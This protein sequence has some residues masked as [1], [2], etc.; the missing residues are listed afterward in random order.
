M[1]SAFVSPAVLRSAR[2]ITAFTLPQSRSLT[3]FRPRSR[4]ASSRFLFNM[5]AVAAQD[6]QQSTLAHGYQYD[7]FVIGAGSGGVRASRIAAN[8]GAKVAVAEYAPL[9]GTCVNVGCVPK[10]LFVYGSHYG[11]DFHDASAYGWDV[12]TP[13]LDWSR[14]IRNKNAEIER[15]NGIYGR[16]LDKAGVHLIQGKAKFVDSHTVQVGDAQ[17]TADKILV[18]TG[19]H[20]F[21]PQFEGR[22][23]AITSNEAFYLEQLPKRCL[24]V[25]G[26]YIA[27]EFACIFHGYGSQIVQLYR[28]DL[29]LRGFDD[30]VRKHLAE[31]MR[32]TG[33]DVRFNSNVKRIVKNADGSF[34]VTSTN[35]ELFETDLVLYATG[36]VP[37]TEGIALEA[38]G[39]KTGDSGKIL[40][41]DW[42]KTNVDHIYAI[43]DVTDRVCLTPVAI[44]EGHAFADTLYGDKKRN[45]NYN[46]IPTAVFS[47]PSIGT[48]GL[49]ETQ[50]REKYGKNG[51]DVYKTAFRPMKHTLTKREGEKTFMKLIVEKS[52]D[53][54]V[55]CHLLDAAA[56]EVIQILGVAMKAGATKADFDATMPVH[57][58]SAEEI[59]TLRTK[60]PDPQ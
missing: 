44:A 11:H 6:T 47:T 4:R 13:S 41:D 53:K 12:P 25:G 17:Y 29:F 23:H 1:S 21:V 39:V 49:T 55:G 32:I 26:G 45:V 59:V 18:A 24:I 56:G 50:A 37:S 22:E 54:V 31:Q 46:D 33:V 28:R 16:L 7:L 60:E 5:S 10:K 14:L 8:H 57:P 42:N 40:V 27:V 51:V 48:C 36:R 2:F 38:A 52:T 43:G 58:V 20:P 9:G 3:P 15:L 30:D 34:T 19:G 35:D